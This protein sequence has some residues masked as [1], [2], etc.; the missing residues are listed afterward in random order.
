MNKCHVYNTLDDLPQKNCRS[1]AAAKR[2]KKEFVSRYERQG[3]YS[4][5]MQRFKLTDLPLYLEI[6]KNHSKYAIEKD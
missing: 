2:F 3:F 1:I 5:R 4:A 6:R